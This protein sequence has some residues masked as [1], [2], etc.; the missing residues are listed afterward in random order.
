MK[1]Y[2][3]LPYPQRTAEWVDAR[4]RLGITASEMAAVCG[5]SRYG[6]QFDVYSFHTGQRP[7]LIPTEEMEWGTLLEPVV[8]DHWAKKHGHKIRRVNNLLQSIEWPFILCSLDRRLANGELLEIKTTGLFAKDWGEPGSDEVPNDAMCQSMTQMAVTGAPRVHVVALF[9][10]QHEREYLIERDDEFIALMVEKARTLWF[11]HIIPRIPPQVDGSEG[12]AAYLA[13][14]YPN[15]NGA[16][17]DATPEIK[18]LAFDYLG[19][20][21]DLKK[22]EERKSSLRNQLVEFM[23]ENRCAVGGDVKI[24]LIDQAGSEYT[25][26]RKPQRVLRVA[27]MEA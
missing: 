16:T 15:G 2:V 19:V 26:T 1:P 20:N 25:V 21:E 14:R 9:G 17:I 5:V 24:T 8:A 23:G 12:A 10:G 18:D 4:K 13:Q 11:D 3:A 22:L 7:D 6:G 27:A